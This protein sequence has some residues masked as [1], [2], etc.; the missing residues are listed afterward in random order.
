MCKN[1]CKLD[2]ACKQ[3]QAELL[4]GYSEDCKCA[5]N[6]SLFTLYVYVYV[7]EYAVGGVSTLVCKMQGGENANA[8]I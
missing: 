5:I 3:L 8:L 7:D 6:C 1:V 4:T 2:N